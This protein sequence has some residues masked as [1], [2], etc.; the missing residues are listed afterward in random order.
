MMSSASAAT[1]WPTANGSE[2]VSATIAVSGT[3]DGGMK[4]YYGTGDLAGRP[5][6]GPG[7]DLRLA[8]GATLKN[9]IIGKPGADG[10]HCQGT[11]TLQNVWWED[12]GEDAATFK[13]RRGDLHR[14]RRRRPEGRDKVF[15]HNGRRQA[16][17]HRRFP[18]RTSASCTA[19]AA[20]ARRSTSARRD[21]QR[22]RR[23]RRASGWSASTPTTATPRTFGKHHDHR[24]QQQEDRPCQKYIGNNTGAEPTDERLR[25]GRH[26]CKYSASDLTYQ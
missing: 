9:V 3:R 4:R 7:P 13:R 21:P 10:V 14:V 26:H 11:C 2:A 17:R 16:R 6:R 1:T 22:S 8:D 23:P 12:V 19:P 24:R 18:S 5:G 25:R 20:T 15:Q